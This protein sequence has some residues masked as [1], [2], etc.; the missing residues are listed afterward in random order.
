MKLQVENII[1]DVQDSSYTAPN[2]REITYKTILKE[3]I[4]ILSCNPYSGTHPNYFGEE[5][6]NKELMRRYIKLIENGVIFEDKNS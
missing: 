3:G 6:T 2:G 4:C 1:F 5:K